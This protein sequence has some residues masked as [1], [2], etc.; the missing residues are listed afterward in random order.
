MFSLL[1]FNDLLMGVSIKNVKPKTIKHLPVTSYC[2]TIIYS[3]L[4]RSTSRIL[5]QKK[6]TY[7]LITTIRRNVTYQAIYEI[8][9]YFKLYNA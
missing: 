4:L 1:H 8:V 5:V 9:T 2:R 7:I 3:M 6:V